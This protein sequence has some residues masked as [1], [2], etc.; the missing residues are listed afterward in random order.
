MAKTHQ[1]TTKKDT[2]IRK[3]IQKTTGIMTHLLEG[4]FLSNST[5]SQ[6]SMKGKST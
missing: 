2:S 1:N 5:A 6:A 4:D 3:L